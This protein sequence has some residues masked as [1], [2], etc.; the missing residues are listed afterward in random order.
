MGTNRSEQPV[1]K[2]GSIVYMHDRFEKSGFK[3]GLI[4]SG[5]NYKSFVGPTYE[6]LVSGKVMTCTESSFIDKFL[7]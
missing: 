3:C 7:Q 1:L 2:T 6:V 4:I 5:P